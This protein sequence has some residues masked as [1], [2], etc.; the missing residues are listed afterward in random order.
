MATSHI[1]SITGN[2]FKFINTKLSFFGNKI[3][4]LFSKPQAA[5]TTSTTHMGKFNESQDEHSSIEGMTTFP[6][7]NINEAAVKINV[8][9]KYTD[10]ALILMLISVNIS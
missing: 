2:I 9:I 5:T 1:K 6:S 4:F 10:L 7:L 8:K 3:R